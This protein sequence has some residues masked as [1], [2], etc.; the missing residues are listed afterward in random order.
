MSGKPTALILDFGGVLT[1]DFWG[2]LQNWCEREGLEPD[3]LINALSGEMPARLLLAELEKGTISQ[4]VF[5]NHIAAVLGVSAEGLLERM[6]AEL[7]PDE[8]MIAAAATLR[9]AGVPVGIL[10]NSWGSE[11]FDPYAAWDLGANYD[12]VVIS[13]K[14]GMRKPE[15]PIYELVL[16]KI[17]L[18]AQECVFVDD[19]AAYLDPARMLGITVIHHSDAAHTL[20]Q[21]QHLFGVDLLPSLASAPPTLR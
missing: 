6:A 12:P 5:A 14:V 20:L 19:V 1:H 9:A 13:D 10:S 17:G 15:L 11:P 4:A 2:A 7:E 21:L 16:T 18:P 8:A 3:A